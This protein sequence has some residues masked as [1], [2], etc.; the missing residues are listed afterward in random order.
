MNV[1]RKA[2]TF[3]V[4][5]YGRSFYTETTEVSM[6]QNDIDVLPCRTLSPK[7][8]VGEKKKVTLS[9]IGLAD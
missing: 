4:F 2:K 5:K 6:S 3:S 7:L 1:V 8:S 9:E